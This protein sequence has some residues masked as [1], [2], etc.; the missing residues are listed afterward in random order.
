MVAGKAESSRKFK[1]VIIAPTPAPYRAYEYDCVQEN[2]SDEFEFNTLFMERH[3]SKAC[4]IVPPKLL[5]IAYQFVRAGL[6]M[7]QGDFC[8]LLGSFSRRANMR[9]K[10]RRTGT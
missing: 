5:A 7:M 3:L 1:V 2:L 4:G 8:Y 9:R 6:F 10:M